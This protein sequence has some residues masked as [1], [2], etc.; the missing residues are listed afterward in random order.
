MRAGCTVS[1]TTPSLPLPPGERRGEGRSQAMAVEIKTGNPTGDRAGWQ[2]NPPLPL[3]R[4]GRGEGFLRLRS[5]RGRCARDTS[6]ASPAQSADLCTASKCLTIVTSLPS[7]L[8]RN[9]STK[10]RASMMPNPPSRRPSSFQT[11]S[12]IGSSSEAA[13]GRFRGL[14]PGPWS[15]MISVIEVGSIR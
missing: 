6:S 15:V 8:Y 13:C 14:K 7:L 9:S 1:K 11:Q 3:P 12:A 4:N 2:S 10:P 5:R